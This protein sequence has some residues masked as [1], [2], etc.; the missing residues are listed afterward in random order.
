MCVCVCVLCLALQ[1]AYVGL[2][3]SFSNKGFSCGRCIKIQCDDQACSKPGSST[4]AQIVDLCG[5]CYDGDLSVA[6]PL[7]VNLT[8]REPNVN[9]NVQV[10]AFSV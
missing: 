6:I 8:G 1:A 3:S 10:T 5:D 2:G 9:P 4:V 7:F